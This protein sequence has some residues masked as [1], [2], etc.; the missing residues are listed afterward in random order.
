MQKYLRQQDKYFLLPENRSIACYK[1]DRL[2]EKKILW[3]INFAYE[4]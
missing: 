4:F 2:C 1:E 3:K